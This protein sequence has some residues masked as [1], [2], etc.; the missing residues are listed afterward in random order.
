[1][2][3]SLFTWLGRKPLPLSNGDEPFPYIGVV[4]PIL[5]V[6][7][8]LSIVEIP[9]FD[10][11]VRKVVPWDPARWIVLVLS[12]WGLLWMAGFAAALKIHPH[13]VGDAGIRIRLAAGLDFTVPWDDVDTVT[14][15]YRSMPSS[16]SVQVED[17]GDRRVL[18]IV[19]A[20]QTSVDVRLRRPLTFHLPKGETDPVDE[21]RLYADDP[22]AFV[23]K[24]RALA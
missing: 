4:K 3:R 5:G 6:F 15:R 11:I 10:L 16:K 13:V 20:G 2:W 22:D 9:I 8:A 12:I 23:R 7:I 1:M 17:D 24:A 18:H 14:K 19:M 21:V